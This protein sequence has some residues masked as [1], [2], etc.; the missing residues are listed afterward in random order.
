MGKA[1]HAHHKA[2]VM[3]D[4]EKTPLHLLQIQD[5]TKIAFPGCPACPLR[6]CGKE[7]K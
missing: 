5:E 1:L 4:M 6:L 7:F 2:R 3:M